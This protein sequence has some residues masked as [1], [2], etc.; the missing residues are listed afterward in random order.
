MPSLE[1][2]VR[3][4][5]TSPQCLVGVWLSEMPDEYRPLVEMILGMDDL[6][7]YRKYRLLITADELDR[8]LIPSRTTFTTHFS[9]ECLCHR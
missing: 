5:S 8:S 3:E 7:V 4:A 9:Q 1:E 2:L 6:T